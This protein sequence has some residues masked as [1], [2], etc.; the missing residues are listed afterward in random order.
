[1]MVTPF[2]INVFDAHLH[3]QHHSYTNYHAG[4][5]GSLA[6]WLAGCLA[7]SLKSKDFTLNTIFKKSIG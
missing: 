6:G 3:V 1:M 2:A 7:A 5:P 4:W